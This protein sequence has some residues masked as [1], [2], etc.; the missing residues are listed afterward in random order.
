MSRTRAGRP[1]PL[2]VTALVAFF[3]A[4]AAL[5]VSSGH[6]ANAHGN[7]DRHTT[8]PALTQKQAALRSE[9]RRLWEDHITWT[10]L[11]VISLTTNSP[12]TKATVGRL[13]RNQTDIGDA[14]KP[15]Y[16]NAAGN[17]LTK[18][19]RRH[20]L[21]AADVIAAAKAGD[22]AK[23]ADAQARW[24]RNGDD[25]AAVLN[26]VNRRH[27]KLAAMKAELRTHLKL[28][29]EEVVARLQG[30]WNADVAA[31]EKIHRHALHL[32][33][34]LSDGLIKQFPKRFR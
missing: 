30:R 6:E 21:I 33:D 25:I 4:A 10:R 17:E 14:A 34:L 8:A 16:G 26:S 13:L 24:A 9:M 18:Q 31:Y 22:K 12:D 2:F 28:T 1:I 7:A 23:L 20:I 3:S 19:L 32:S 27:W 5:A 15:F 11:A 29:T